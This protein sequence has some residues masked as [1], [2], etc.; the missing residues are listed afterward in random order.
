VAALA[1]ALSA[2]LLEKLVHRSALIA[3]LR[4]VRRECEALIQRD[5]ELFARVIQ[6]TR[7]P[8]RR[9]FRRALR[10]ATDVPCRVFEDALIIQR[11]CRAARQAVKP[12]FQSDL[13]CAMA[14]ALAAAESARTL[15][16]TNLAWLDDPAYARGVRRRLQSASRRDGR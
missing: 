5:A 12:R 13:R 9:S 4:R 3:R 11:A 15:I 7:Q 8:D 16:Q 2:A 14:V 6:A 10:A 1:A